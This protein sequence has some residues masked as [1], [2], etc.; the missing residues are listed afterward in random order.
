METNELIAIVGGSLAGLVVILIVLAVIIYCACGWVQSYKFILVYVS[1]VLIFMYVIQAF[2]F[3][4]TPF[5]SLV[6][7]RLEIALVTFEWENE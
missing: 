6:S 4:I 2:K 5:V 1:K 7:T 3:D